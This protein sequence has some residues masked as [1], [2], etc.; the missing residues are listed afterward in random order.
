VKSQ[1][2][3]SMPTVEII[4]QTTFARLLDSLRGDVDS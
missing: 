4:D 1:R 3:K 2:R